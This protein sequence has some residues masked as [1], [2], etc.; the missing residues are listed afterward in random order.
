[1]KH[2]VLK[3]QINGATTQIGG[4]IDLN[5]Q[6]Q[7]RISSNQIYTI[8]NIIHLKSLIDKQLFQII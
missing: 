7:V 4:F 5:L 8:L 2:G 1:M 3:Q 6:D